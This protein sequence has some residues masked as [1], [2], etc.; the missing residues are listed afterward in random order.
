MHWSLDVLTAMRSSRRYA[1]APVTKGQS[2]RTTPSRSARYAAPPSERSGPDYGCVD[3]FLYEE[4]RPE[5][6]HV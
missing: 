5:R 1:A 2:P 3:W 4:P 6:D